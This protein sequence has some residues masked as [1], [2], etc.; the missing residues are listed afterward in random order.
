MPRRLTLRERDLLV[1]PLGRRGAE[2]GTRL[3]VG[4]GGTRLAF[5]GALA[6][7]SPP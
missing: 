5:P 2:L 4:P 6:P 3:T 1:D 7:A